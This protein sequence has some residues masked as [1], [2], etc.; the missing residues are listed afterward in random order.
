MASASRAGLGRA[1]IVSSLSP[2][3]DL[4][5][6]GHTFKRITRAGLL[7]QLLLFIERNLQVVT[8]TQR[9]MHGCLQ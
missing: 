1:A 3:A 4:P 6:M 2:A 7:A 9:T 8:R 5:L